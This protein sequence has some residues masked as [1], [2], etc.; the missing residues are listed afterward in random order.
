MSK[1]LVE[2]DTINCAIVDFSDIKKAASIPDGTPTNEYK[3]FIGSASAG[4][5]SWQPH[6][7]WWDIESII[8]TNT[9]PWIIEQPNDIRYAFLC[10]DVHNTITLLTGYEYYLSDGSYYDGSSTVIHTWDR[11]KDKDCSL[12]YKTRAVVVCSNSLNISLTHT[13]FTYSG[14]DDMYIYFGDC[15]IVS[16]LFS[17]SSEAYTN[18]ILQAILISDKTTG[19]SGYITNYCCRYCYSLHKVEIA[20]GATVI[21]QYAFARTTGLNS[22][23]LPTTLKAI[24]NYA[25]NESYSLKTVILP[26]GLTTINS[27]A[28]QSCQNLVSCNL[29]SSLTT[30]N[31][32]AFSFCCALNLDM[33]IP[34][35]ITQISVASFQNDFMLRKVILPQS[36]KTI[37]S[38]AFSYCY[39]LKDLILP[40]GLNTIAGSPFIACNNLTTINI[41]ESVTSIEST[42]FSTMSTLMNVTVPVGF[43]L[44]LNISS[45]PNMSIKSLETIIDNYADRTGLTSLTFTIGATNIAKLSQEYIEKAVNKNITLA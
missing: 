10:P 4:V 26:E 9:I 3:N 1:I 45:S 11:S 41:P 8:E 16:M 31:N 15:N 40:E 30:I 38:S 32:Y 6:P 17:N 13:N 33:I 19:N 21:N 43:N 20:E 7:D 25:F 18:T 34:E 44:S 5:S 27:Y 23:S 22:I 14:I 24:N 29:P 2:Q 42:T 37:Y 39:S 28:F 36:I 12:G 35:G